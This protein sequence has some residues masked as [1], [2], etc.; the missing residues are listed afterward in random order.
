LAVVVT[1]ATLSYGQRKK[2]RTGNHETEFVQF[3]G[4]HHFASQKP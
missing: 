4:R 2:R 3:K 1:A